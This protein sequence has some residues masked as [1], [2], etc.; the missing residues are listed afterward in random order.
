MLYQFAQFGAFSATAVWFSVSNRQMMERTDAVWHGVALFYFYVVEYITVKQHAPDI[1]PI[2]A[3]ASAAVVF[4]AYLIAMRLI[5]GE[6]ASTAG[7]GLVSAYCTAVTTHVLFFELLPTAYFPWAALLTIPTAFLV[8]DR[9]RG[10]PEVMVP[11]VGAAL[12]M[13]M[14]GFNLLVTSGSYSTDLF[15]PG[16]ALFAYAAMLYFASHRMRHSGKQQSLAI[17]LLY[18]GHITFM[19]ATIRVFESGLTIS[20]IWGVFAVVLLIIALQQGNRNLGQSSLIVFAASGLKVLLYDLTGTPSL[21]RV[22]TLIVLGS[23]LYAGG[24]IYQRIKPGT[25]AEADA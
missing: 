18:A 15:M 16:A 3:L 7:A 1:A 11:I 20:I 25:S 21:V 23:T 6:R 5:H 24:W 2:A 10:R 9:L 14:M 13:A 17:P 22:L 8:Y 19:V 12:L 4:A